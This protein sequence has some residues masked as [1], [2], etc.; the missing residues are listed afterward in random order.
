MDVKSTYLNESPEKQ[1][2]LNFI[3]KDIIKFIKADMPKECNEYVN[4]L[5]EMHWGTL[6]LISKIVSK[7]ETHRV[8]IVFSPT[9]SGKTTA[10]KAF[11][12]A[13]LIVDMNERAKKGF[14]TLIDYQD[15]VSLT[16]TNSINFDSLYSEACASFSGN[17]NLKVVRSPALQNQNFNNVY[18]V[19]F[20]ELHYAASND[21]VYIQRLINI[22]NSNN[23]LKAILVSATPLTAFLSLFRCY[24]SDLGLVMHDS[25]DLSEYSG[26]EMF[27]KNKQITDI[28]SSRTSIL[29]SRYSNEAFEHF[30][31]FTAGVM[32]IRSAPKQLKALYKKLTRR[33][34][35]AIVYVNSTNTKGVNELVEDGY[36]VEHLSL[37]TIKQRYENSDLINRKL[38]IITVAQLK[39]GDDLGAL[40]KR[41]L[42]VVWESTIS[43]VAGVIQGLPGRA[44]GYISNESVRFFLSKRML[45]IHLRS[46]HILEKLYNEKASLEETA[47]ALVLTLGNTKYDNGSRLDAFQENVSETQLYENKELVNESTVYDALVFSNNVDDSAVTNCEDIIKLVETIRTQIN[48][49]KARL[50]PNSMN[51]AKASWSKRH[52]FQKNSTKSRARASGLYDSEFVDALVNGSIFKMPFFKVADISTKDRSKTRYHALVLST[53]VYSSSDENLTT[54]QMNSVCDRLGINPSEDVIIVTTRRSSFSDRLDSTAT[55]LVRNREKYSDKPVNSYSRV[56]IK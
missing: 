25:S 14:L 40:L 44:T 33:Y 28:G 27:N 30:D 53:N 16:Y 49:G 55:A 46:Q 9:Q 6:R 2:K 19:C 42:K 50:P 51:M 38:I 21:A 29:S 34:P 39:A 1:E 15:P 7:L 43:N 18:A 47:N 24:G 5:A 10:L 37:S 22:L 32:L 23:S 36:R 8:V 52:K 31:R 35:S 4:N 3:F 12:Y 56:D 45:N 54:K 20:D 17:L 41:N 13:R 11:A 26:L 48:R